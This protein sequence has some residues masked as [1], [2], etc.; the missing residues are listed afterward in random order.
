MPELPEVE[1]M[2]R[3]IRPFVEG[4]RIAEVRRCRC[5]CKPISITPSFPQLARRVAGQRVDQV[6]RLGKRVVLDLLRG[7]SLVVEPRMTGLL[8]LSDPV[9]RA[10]L[11]VEWRFDGRMKHNSL[12][13]WDRRGLGTISL[14]TADE[15]ARCLGDDKLGPDALLMTQRQWLQSCAN[16]QREIKVVLLDQRLVAGIGNLYASEILHLARLHPAVPASRL[17]P[18]EVRRLSRAVQAVLRQAIEYEGSTLA[19]ATYRT[20]LNQNGRYQSVHRVYARA[21]KPCGTCRTSLIVRVVQAQRSTFFCPNC[22]RA[23][24]SAAGLG[25]G[26]RPKRGRGKRASP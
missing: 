13:F 11:R 7:E 9:D 25:N 17:R 21:D 23:G 3:G 10:H 14:Y 22:Q 20:A 8:L 24:S 16:T 26:R 5:R 19:D 4:R 15:I 18:A 2:V 1:T 12:W 6:R